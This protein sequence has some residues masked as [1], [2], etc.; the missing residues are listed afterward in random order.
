MQKQWYR[1]TEDELC[2]FF[3]VNPKKGLSKKDVLNRLQRFGTNRD[4]RLQDSLLRSLHVTVVR[5][6]KK[7]V[8]SLDQVALGDIVLLKEGDRVPADIRLLHVEKLMI[9]QAQLTGEVLPVAKNTFLL[10]DEGV[11][12]KQKCMAFAGSYIESGSGWGIAVERGESTVLARSPKKREVKLG[13]KGSVIAR[14]LRRF[15]VIILNKRSLA[16]FR[17]IT[18]VVIV[19]ET[20]DTEIIEH[21]RKVQLTRNI[22]C[23][24]AVSEAIASRLSKEFNATVYDVQAKVGDLLSAQFIT[25]LD[26]SNSLEVAIALK[27]RGRQTLWV[28]DGRERLR[29]F[30]AATISMVVGDAG[31][32]DAILAADIYAPKTDTTILTRILYAKK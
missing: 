24:F 32:D 29:A 27:K 21:I 30:T 19:G 16:L 18:T 14:R 31:R 8:I 4:A 13:I 11:A 12:I 2:A 5:E 6:S 10:A 25:N 17:K 28:S 26:T 9:N 15:G 7:Q 20:K 23:K 22:D 3:D 1:Q